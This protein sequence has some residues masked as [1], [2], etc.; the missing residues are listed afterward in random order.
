MCVC[1][2]ARA[3]AW[4]RAG[5]ACRSPCLRP[6]VFISP[7]F[8]TSTL[9]KAAP[10][11]MDPSSQIVGRSVRNQNPASTTAPQAAC[12]WTGPPAT[13]GISVIQEHCANCRLYGIFLSE[14]SLV[15]S[16]AE[17]AGT[18]CV[19]RW[20]LRL[21]RWNVGFDFS[22]EVAFYWCTEQLGS[23]RNYSPL[24]IRFF[25]SKS[26]GIYFTSVILS[27]CYSITV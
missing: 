24:K 8:L 11:F 1:V 25:L 19:E 9:C 15:H 21:R 18:S 3:R 16:G 14:K 10:T 26:R 23:K 6:P 4:T 7:H 27:P 13:K 17:H 2:C 12:L 20:R 5:H 22:S